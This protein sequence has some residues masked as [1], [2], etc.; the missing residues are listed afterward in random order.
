[1]VNRYF[2]FSAKRY[3]DDNPSVNFPLCLAIHSENNPK[4]RK[5]TKNG[6]S[7]TLNLSL[8]NLNDHL[9]AFRGQEESTFK[10]QYR[11]RYSKKIDILL[12][13]LGVFPV[14][15]VEGIG[16]KMNHLIFCDRFFNSHNLHASSC[17]DIVRRKYIL[18][19]IETERLKQVYT[20]AKNN[21]M[22]QHVFDY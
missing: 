17:S 20:E 1:M 10:P 14:I 2:Q 15:M 8:S 5:S 16:L 18:V 19:T 21:I 11:H 4:I 13:V 22:C 7:F 3:S 12:P 6:F 9:Q